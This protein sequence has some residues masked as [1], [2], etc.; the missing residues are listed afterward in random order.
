MFVL[1]ARL[2]VAVDRLDE[3][4]AVVA[5]VKAQDGAAQHALQDLAPP[6][7][8]AEALG[9]GQGMCQKV[10]MVACGSCARTIAGSSAKW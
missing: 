6:G 10:R 3:V 8:D 5:R 1:D 9:L 4:L 2:E 7:A